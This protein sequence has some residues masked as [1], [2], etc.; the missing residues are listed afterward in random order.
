MKKTIE[1]LLIITLLAGHSC[2]ITAREQKRWQW[3]N[4]LGGALWDRTC[5]VVY[6]GKNNLYVAGTYLGK[7]STGGGEIESAGGNDI[8]L[9]RYDENGNLKDLWSAGGEGNDRATCL[10]V[11]QDE[12]VILG[13]KTSDRFTFNNIEDNA[14][15]E[16]L[17]ITSIS[18]KGKCSW[19]TSF[20][21][22]GE[23]SLF[24]MD[25]DAN[26]N[27]YAAGMF[28][29]SLV[30]GDKQ[31]T[32][33]GQ[34]DVF[35]AVLNSSGIIQDIF[36]FGGPGDDIPSAISV[37][38]ASR[39]ALAVQSA[40]GFFNDTV[41]GKL[42]KGSKQSKA[43]VILFDDKM[44][45]IWEKQVSSEGYLQV[46]SIKQDQEENVYVAG[47]FSFNLAL[48]DTF[49]SQGY[50]D[51]FIMKYNPDGEMLWGRSYGTWYYDYAGELIPDGSG[52]MFLT[53]SIS[54]A[55]TIDNQTI[56]Q[57]PDINS[58]CIIQFAPEGRAIWADGISGTGYSYS[59]GIAIDNK[60]NLYITGTF[61][62]A[63][64]KENHKLISQGDQD[65]FVA[66]YFICPDGRGEITGNPHLC[67]GQQTLLAISK[68]Y[69]DISWNSSENNKYVLLVDKPG[70]YWVTM[71]DKRGCLLSDTIEVNISEPTYF[72]LGS[73][74]ALPV[75][76]SMLLVA[77]TSFSGY[78]WHDNS[79]GSAYLARAENGNPGIY[80]FWL[81]ASDTHG[82]AVSD[83][84][85]I[86]FYSTQ[87]WIDPR[88]VQLSVYPNPVRDRLYWAVNIPEPCRFT[89]ELSDNHGSVVQIEY[90]ERYMP[91]STREINLS[92]LPYGLYFLRLRNGS[93]VVSPAVT[94]V[95]Q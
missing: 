81:T 39:V 14:E 89:V 61:R 87:K 34:K 44:D 41:S 75:D 23:A 8:F 32:S 82:C 30:A 56:N 79:S 15:G 7:L 68:E 31:L 57:S 66:K 10:A 24:L 54:D 59:N 28:S 60:G 71:T 67:P 12:H 2:N 22:E 38:G 47:S 40:G 37:S 25:T 76:S 70:K 26:G 95:K 3:V 78:L 83:S 85:Q 27:I 62:D 11:S 35:I 53:G 17:F 64:E 50:T 92:G 93:G 69:S 90:I 52:G 88:E 4:Q 94:I 36:S 13:G 49:T 1:I 48:K 20:F 51:C 77:P 72:S 43:F 58:A 6:D 46:T 86:E 16:R 19:I 42:V 55:L 63:L 91:G 18:S 29:G 21:P 73:D 45:V 33:N 65:V 9:A 80:T 74:T 5:G 84:I